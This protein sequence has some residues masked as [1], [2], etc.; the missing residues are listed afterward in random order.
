MLI[1]KIESYELFEEF[2][3]NY[4]YVFVNISA[5]WCKPCMAIKP[6]LQKFISVINKSDCIYLLLDADIYNIDE[7]F[8]KYF[9]MSKIP[10]FCFIENKLIKESFVSG[11]FEFVSKRL[12]ELI[13]YGRENIKK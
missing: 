9:K 11:D 5:V 2:T 12:F 8:H 13:H 10:Y 1:K 7:R 4:T 6:N 3:K